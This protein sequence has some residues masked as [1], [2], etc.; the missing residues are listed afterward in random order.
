MAYDKEDL[1]QLSIKYFGTNHTELSIEDKFDRL[2]IPV[3]SELAEKARKN[4]QTMSAEQIN[5]SLYHL[6]LAA[7]AVP[8][9]IAE[10][11]KQKL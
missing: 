11:R 4:Y 8:K 2:N 6:L 3:D 10:L 5:E 7:E 1:E 9:V